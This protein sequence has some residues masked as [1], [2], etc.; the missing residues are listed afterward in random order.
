VHGGCDIPEMTDPAPPDVS[1]TRMVL[2]GLVHRCP[3]C[4]SR[5]VFKS[6]F[7][8]KDRC[9]RCGLKLIRHE[10]FSLGS[11][12][13]NMVVTFGLFLLII[14]V[15]TIVTYPHIRVVPVTIAGLAVAIIVPIAFYPSAQT[16]WSG[17]DL[18]MR[19]LDPVEQAEAATFLDADTEP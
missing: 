5:H 11:T 8:M 9:P 1:P 19:P 13:I 4:G 6:F 7:T 16:I 12:T 18:A 15:G 17:I 3:R 2:R 14:V 10:G